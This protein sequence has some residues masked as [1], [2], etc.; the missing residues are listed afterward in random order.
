MIEQN[1]HE[2]RLEIDVELN[3]KHLEKIILAY[4]KQISG[5]EF[6]NIYIDIKKNEIR[7]IVVYSDI[8]ST[9]F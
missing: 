6:T 1:T 5:Y 4:A 7:K 2:I 9:N 8:K 3:Q